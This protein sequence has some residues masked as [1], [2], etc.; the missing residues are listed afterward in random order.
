MKVE[1]KRKIV[2]LIYD[3]ELQSLLKDFISG[4]EYDLESAHDGLDG[5][6]KLAKSYFDL[7]ITDFR[8]PGLG[9]ENLLP[10]LKLIQPWAKVIVIPTA[11][12]KREQ[13]RVIESAADFC[14]E[15]PFQIEQLKTV[16]QKL[17]FPGEKKFPQALE[18]LES[19]KLSL[20]P[21]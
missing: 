14:L 6:H 20:T 16:I 10:R 15:K 3:E 4:S 7:I 11:R 13:R 1:N 17:L 18:A 21:T 12:V 9:G 5:F 19:R 8:M 2:T